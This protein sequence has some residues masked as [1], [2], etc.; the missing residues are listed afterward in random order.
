MK[1]DPYIVVLMSSDTC[2]N[3]PAAKC[4]SSTYGPFPTRAEA[5]AFADTFGEAWNAHLMRLKSPD[6]T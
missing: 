5:S 3:D 1:P 2:P 6:E 4:I